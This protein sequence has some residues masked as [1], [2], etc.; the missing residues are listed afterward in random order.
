MLKVSLLRRA[1]VSFY[2]KP[3]SRAL[4][5]GNNWPLAPKASLI[6]GRFSVT[7][8]LACSFLSRGTESSMSGTITWAPLLA[9]LLSILALESDIAYLVARNVEARDEGAE[10]APDLFI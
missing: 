2:I 8:C 7:I 1:E 4:T 5:L 3:E 9:H 6:F 10:L